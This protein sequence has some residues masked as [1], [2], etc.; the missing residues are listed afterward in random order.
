TSTDDSRVTAQASSAAGNATYRITEV[1]QLAQAESQVG[2]KI[3]EDFDPSKSLRSQNIEG[4]DLTW[5]TGVLQRE[6]IRVSENTKELTID[7]PDRAGN[8]TNET[9]IIVKV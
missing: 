5:E 8:V 1:Q 6:N 3:G 2:G 9:D 7:I 4:S